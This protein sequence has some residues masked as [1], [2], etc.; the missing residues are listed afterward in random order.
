MRGK[1]IAKTQKT[2]I[3]RPL[4]YFSLMTAT[5]ITVLLAW[6]LYPVP[7]ANQN[8]GLIEYE[9]GYIFTAFAAIGGM[10]YF[11]RTT[12]WHTF[13]VYENGVTLP[14]PALSNFLFFRN[15]REG[16]FLPYKYILGYLGIEDFKGGEKEHK[17]WLKKGKDALF[18]FYW[19]RKK[20]KIK[21]EIFSSDSEVIK[22]MREMLKRWSI[23]KLPRVCPNCGKKLY[24]LDYL[25]GECLK[26]H[27]K[28]F[29]IPREGGKN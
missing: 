1:L 10:I 29:E 7:Q 14:Y 27:Y 4:L 11:L 3:L 23:K 24:G 5:F 9:S 2:K 8:I 12:Y 22:V 18:I 13:S 28:L 15:E 16:D 17:K 25:H 6:I 21:M 20:K 26:C 19:N